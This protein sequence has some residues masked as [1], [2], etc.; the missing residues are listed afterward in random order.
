[1]SCFLFIF[2]VLI[3]LSSFFKIYFAWLTL[4]ILFGLLFY[5]DSKHIFLF[6]IINL[7]V[8]FFNLDLILDNDLNYYHHAEV[9]KN[10]GNNL[11]VSENGVK[12]FLI[13]KDNNEI[14]LKGTKIYFEG[15]YE[16]SSDVYF[17]QFLYSN[18]SKYFCY[19]DNYEIIK[20]PFNCFRN[21]II[22]NN[23]NSSSLYSDFLLAFIFGIETV[24]NT[25]IFN[26]SQK[27]GISHLLVISGLHINFLN[28][29][30]MR[31]K[32]SK[33]II[34]VIIFYLLFLTYFPISMM[35][36][37]FHIIYG[38]K[39][40]SNNSF[41]FSGITLL[42]IN[43]GNLF[44]F[45]FILSNAI[46]YVV[47]QINRFNIKSNLLSSFFIFISSLPF[48]LVFGSPINLL[49]FL[50]SNILSLWIEI[51]YIF[52]FLSLFFFVFKIFSLLIIITFIPI[53]KMFSFVCLM[54]SFKEI[55]IYF[56][57]VFYLQYVLILKVI[58]V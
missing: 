40:D 20:Y 36:A 31:I 50:V 1:M 24:N 2:Q 14:V 5:K 15:N 44:S 12:S 16:V 27:M 54:V 10:Y 4:I 58:K 6:S 19:V 25:F 7:I 21:A 46:T 49:S 45:S 56:A 47:L 22:Y 57:M 38:E 33:K 41:Y 30:L 37:F 42:M 35:R 13:I 32:L 43:P 48:L 11:L 52:L 26:Y 53:F 39:Y 9:V 34:N 17:N 51:I 3:I 23:L 55:N 28:S 29:S 18:G 8:F